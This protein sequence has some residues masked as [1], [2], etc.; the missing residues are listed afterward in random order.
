MSDNLEYIR[1]HKTENQLHI[2]LNRPKA[3][4]AL[5][6]DMVK[7]IYKILLDYKDDPTVEAIVFKGAG[8]RGFCAGGD[9]K[10]AYELGKQNPR[11]AWDY[12]RDEYEMNKLLFHYPKPITSICHG[13]VMGGGYGIAGNGSDIITDETT[14]FAMPETSIGFFPDVG[15]CWHLARAGALGMYVALTGD[16]F[17]GDM[18]HQLRSGGLSDNDELNDIFAKDNLEDIFHALDQSQSD[19]AVQTLK[20]LQTRSPISLHITFKHI[21]MARHETYNQS[22]ERDYQLACAFFSQTDVYEGIRAAVIDKD[23]NPKW[24]HSSI[25]NISVADIDY[26]FRFKDHIG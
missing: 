3:L 9:I 17:D 6:H 5:N 12:F 16:I 18:I 26:Y 19:F 20:T 25:F 4:N 11:L 1:T 2:T 15:I 8:E 24:T 10:A 14:R 23:R 21:H 13:F 22:I 7:V